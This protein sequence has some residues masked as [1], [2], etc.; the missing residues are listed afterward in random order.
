MQEVI[1]R[2]KREGYDIGRF[3]PDG[4]PHRFQID[5]TDKRK[6]GFYIAY[7]NF[8]ASTGQQYYIVVY[9]SWRDGEIKTISTFQGKQSSEDQLIEK[10]LRKKSQQKLERDKEESE[11]K[12]AEE[13]EQEWNALSQDGQCEYLDQKRI[14]ISPALGFRFDGKGNA[15]AP[16]R[17]LSGKIW[18]IQKI[19]GN[20][21]TFSDGTRISKRF[22]S[23]GRVSSNFH[24]IGTIGSSGPIYLAEGIATAAS[25]HL[26]TGTGIV[27]CFNASNLH[28]VATKLREVYTDRQFIICGDDDKNAKRTD[29][30]P[31]NAGRVGAEKAAR[32]CMG[33]AV[34]PRFQRAETDHTD[35]NDL[36]CSEGIQIVQQQLSKIESNQSSI[37]RL[38]V[39]GFLDGTYYFTSSSNQQVTGVTGFSKIELMKLMPIE[40]WETMYPGRGQS[41]V[42]WDTAGSILMAA[43]REKGIFQSQNIRGTGVWSDD[44]RVVVNMGDHLIVDGVP[45]RLGEIK[46]RNFYTLGATLPKIHSQPLSVAECQPLTKACSLFRWKQEDFGIL[47]SGALVTSRICAAL[48]IR[49]HIWI[50][51]SA[52]QGKSTLFTRLIDPILGPSKLFVAGGTTE[53]GIRQMLRASAVPLIFD[54]FETSG[55]K[56]MERIQSL[57]DLMRVAWAETTASIVKGTAQGNSSAY[58]VRFSAIVASIRQ[59]RMNDADASRFATIELNPHENDAE[60]WKL[61][62]GFLN[63][64]DEEY[65]ERLFARTIGMVPVLLANFKTIKRALASKFPGQRFGDQYGM[66]LAGYSVLLQDA[67]VSDS[68]ATWLADQ[69]K[70]EEAKETASAI[71]HVDTLDQLLTWKVAYEGPERRED[72]LV[73]ALISKALSYPDSARETNALLNLGIKVQTDGVAIAGTP[74]S[75][76]EKVFRGTRWEGSWLKPLSRL[77]GA[78]QTMLRFGSLRKRCVVL[79][80]IHFN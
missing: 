46:S 43:A 22:S 78:K 21:T 56:G 60:H 26:A 18:S 1:E 16:L 15:Y 67:P 48:P 40:Y 3:I 36:H 5:S 54:E 65:G 25:L 29:G 6:S 44:G 31:F 49:P 59:I 47:L 13:I 68:D 4:K 23:G 57:L 11:L 37:P 51:G 77:T 9:G 19:Y 66:L 8:S 38:I 73:G 69:V 39:L 64:I 76:L 53:A 79:P 24:I 12:A 50:T 14:P 10:N 70:L 45:V 20:P 62:E 52:G 63:Q 72:I 27:C 75:E 80:L 42:D 30:T 7:Q 71:D 34:F 17:D 58:S 28:R 33:S 55:A 35:W 41:R 74:H 2:L 32:A 61:L